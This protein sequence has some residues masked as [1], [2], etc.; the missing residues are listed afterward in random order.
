MGISNRMMIN[1][2]F[3]VIY[4]PLILFSY[5]EL[6]PLSAVYSSWKVP[7]LLSLFFIGIGLVADETVLPIFG[8]VKSTIQGT[9]F[10]IAVIWSVQF[11]FVGTTISIGSA[12]IMGLFI[13]IGEFFMHKRILSWQRGN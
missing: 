3:K 2:L 6:F 8:L 5:P 7:L 4:F 10:M 13:G 9:S 12:I 1:F 11:L